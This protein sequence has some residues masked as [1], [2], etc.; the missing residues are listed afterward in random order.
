MYTCK[1]ETHNSQW[2][3]RVQSS[4]SKI[5]KFLDQCSLRLICERIYQLPAETW[6]EEGGSN[7]QGAA[8]PICFVTLKHLSV[9]GVPVTI[10]QTEDETAHTAHSLLWGTVTKSCVLQLTLLSS[11]SLLCDVCQLIWIYDKQG[12]GI[13]PPIWISE[14]SFFSAEI[15]QPPSD[16]REE[17]R[18]LRVDVMASVQMCSICDPKWK[19]RETGTVQR[20]NLACIQL[21]GSTSLP[22]VL[23]LASLPHADLAADVDKENGDGALL[24]AGMGFSR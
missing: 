7:H 8:S 21:F 15:Q 17:Q 5:P 6:I 1:C 19:S 13:S 2:V 10:K 20:S 9:L 18:K 22:P 14:Y 24:L 3:Q 16:K 4:Q 23:L 11:E 12:F